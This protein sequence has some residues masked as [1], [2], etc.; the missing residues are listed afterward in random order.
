[1]SVVLD[2]A[3]DSNRVLGN[4]ILMLRLRCS[5]F[6]RSPGMAAFFIMLFLS[7]ANGDVWAANGLPRHVPSVLIFNMPGGEIH[8][9]ANDQAP[10]AYFLNELP[11]DFDLTKLPSE[12][13]DVVIAKV[14]AT[15]SPSSLGG[16]DQSG[17]PP[18]GRSR[19]RLFT[20]IKILEARLGS[21]AVGEEY[22]VYFGEG[23]HELMYPLTPEQL[24]RDYIVVMYRDAGDGKH[25]L[26]GFPVS[27][28]QFS[29]WQ[30]EMFK[31][32]R[33]LPLPKN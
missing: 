13:R 2:L 21:A 3:G 31:I 19:D 9:A 27:Y 28:T 24:R 1:M 18:P 5:W 14:R 8:M 17:I 11:A 22:A 4:V 26:I 29:E 33:S 32:Q 23:G 16:R 20:R 25:R 10:M 7:I 30:A 15:E 6:A 12:A